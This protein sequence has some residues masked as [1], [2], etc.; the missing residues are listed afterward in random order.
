MQ[1]ARWSEDGVGV[2]QQ[3]A[4]IQGHSSGSACT[5]RIVRCKNHSANNHKIWYQVES[6]E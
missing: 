4:R 5:E 6:I 2:E 3:R 1:R